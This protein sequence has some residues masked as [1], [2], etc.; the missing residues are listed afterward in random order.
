[1]AGDPEAA[2]KLGVGVKIAT[3][4]LKD[5]AAAVTAEVVMMG[6]SGNL[7]AQRLTRHGDRGEPVALEQSTDVSIDS[8]DAEAGNLRLSCGQHLLRR[9]RPVG[10]L[11]CFT[12][13]SFLACIS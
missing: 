8:S 9:E 5:L 12:D 6:L 10:T 11:K 13:C 2:G 4:E 1:M 7:V 3:F